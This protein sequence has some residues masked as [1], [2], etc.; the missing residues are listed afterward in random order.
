MSKSKTMIGISIDIVTLLFS[1]S[2]RKSAEFRS[3]TFGRRH[4]DGDRLGPAAVD[5][6]I[7]RR[8]KIL[9]T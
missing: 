3:T 6:I 7:L 9:Q 2:N 8:P 5:N 1:A 4:F